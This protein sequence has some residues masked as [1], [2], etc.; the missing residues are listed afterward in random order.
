[1]EGKPPA[2]YR[3]PL[4]YLKEGWVQRICTIGP[5]PS[6]L[7]HNLFSMPTS[8][9]TMFRVVAFSCYSS[10]ANNRNIGGKVKRKPTPTSTSV[11]TKMALKFTLRLLHMA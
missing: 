9:G 11:R 5:M 3:F 2:S 6:T 7:F 10:G 8:L 1:M 4:D